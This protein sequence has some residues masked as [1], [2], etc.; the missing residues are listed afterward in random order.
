MVPTQQTPPCTPHYTRK[1]E[2]H[3]LVVSSPMDSSARSVGA[4]HYARPPLPP[5]HLTPH[6]MRPPLPPHDDLVT[7]TPATPFDLSMS[8]PT[9][10]S[11]L[12]TPSPFTIRPDTPD[13]LAMD[14]FDTP[15][16]AALL[17]SIDLSDKENVAPTPY[18]PLRL[19]SDLRD[20]AHE[21]L[22]RAPEFT[23]PPPPRRGGVRTPL[24][25]ITNQILSPTRD[26]CLSSPIQRAKNRS[27]MY[28]GRSRPALRM[29][30]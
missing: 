17:A 3:A 15:P 16:I 8:N 18:T 30:R 25:D 6:T 5:F 11:E 26:R 12:T 24:A 4:P 9:P 20:G 23:S 19:A 13:L 22:I 28:T 27:R 1:R 10:G 14:E 2:E 7:L 29:M 21:A